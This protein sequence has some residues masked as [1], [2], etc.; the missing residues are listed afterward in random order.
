MTASIKAHF[1]GT[2]IQLDEPVNLPINTPL[3]VI[4][5]TADVQDDLRTAWNDIGSRSLNQAFG[6]NEPEYSPSDIVP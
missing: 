4:I 2:A 3:V 1:D 6:E 5:S